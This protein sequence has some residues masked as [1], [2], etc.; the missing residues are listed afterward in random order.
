[1]N[2]RKNSNTLT[3]PCLVILV[4]MLAASVVADTHHV[5]S[6]ESIQFAIDSASYG[7]TVEVAAGTYHERITLK[8]GV[9]VIGAGAQAT[10]INGDAGGS[11]VTSNG[12][13]PNTL[14]QGFTITNGAAPKGGGMYN[15]GGSPIVIDCIFTANTT[16]NQG[17]GG[18][19]YNEGSSPTVTNCT[20]SGNLS[21]YGLTGGMYNN[22]SNP[23]VDNCTFSNNNAEWSSG[24]M[25]NLNRSSP[26]VTN[27]TFSGNST[28]NWGAGGMYNYQSSATVTNCT[29][30]GNRA[31]SGSSGTGGIYT[32]QGS[33][34]VTNLSL[35]HI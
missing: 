10:I 3:V 6:G 12:C 17:D 34:T 24:G 20:F 23:R 27:C 2:G 13:D 18:G 5:N 30:T 9:A 32:S 19:M 7:D 28:N 33:S 14:L 22:N 15:F 31:E 1:M 25:S 11:V 29:F 4:L 8:N 16:I 21:P 35:I 26:I